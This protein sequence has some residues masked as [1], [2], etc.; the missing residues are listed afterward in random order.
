MMLWRAPT[1]A[2]ENSI[3][4]SAGARICFDHSTLKYRRTEQQHYPERTGIRPRLERY[5][6]QFRA[7]KDAPRSCPAGRV[8]VVGL[9]WCGTTPP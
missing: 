7:C 3:H 5:C 6:G 1:V 9:R 2:P 8:A 4:D